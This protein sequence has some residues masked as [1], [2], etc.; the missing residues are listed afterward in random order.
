MGDGRFSSPNIIKLE[1]LCVERD[2]RKSVGIDTLD[3]LLLDMCQAAGIKRKTCT[4]FT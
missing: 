1:E 3:H 2:V 4:V